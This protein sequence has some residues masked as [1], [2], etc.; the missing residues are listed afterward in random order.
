MKNLIF[1]QYVLLIIVILA[2]IRGL[3]VYQLELNSGVIYKTTSIL[4]LLSGLLSLIKLVTKKNNLELPN[5]KKL[6]LLNASINI[7]YFLIFLIFNNVLPIYLLYTF[8]VFPIIFFLFQIENNKLENSIF[9][10]SIITAFGVFYFFQL[11]INVGYENYLEIINKLRPE[12][13]AI[14]RIGENILSI[15]YQGSNHDAANI[16]V[17]GSLYF[18]SQIYNKKLYKKYFNLLMFLILTIVVLFTGS[19]TN[20]SILLIVLCLSFLKFAK[21]STILKVSFI[22]ILLILTLLFYY[23]EVDYNQYIFFYDKISNPDI[24]NDGGIFN[25]LNLKSFYQSIISILFGFGFTLNVPLINVEIGFIKL[26]IDTGLIPFSILM[27]ILFYPIY[28][29]HLFKSKF[30]NEFKFAKH[31]SV[32]NHF[33]KKLKISALPII[34]GG[35]TLVH[36]SSL[37]RITSIGFYCILFTLFLKQYIELNNIAILFLEMYKKDE[38]TLYS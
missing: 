7:I 24:S 1:K 2:S 28:L 13:D 4:L 27:Y 22:T 23:N 19:V 30:H 6:I 17:M 20:I 8:L 34:A 37:F 5:L 16:L 14:S 21:L 3:L 32:F 35:L 29:I 33:I 18:Y 31:Q 26:L 11:S 38:N 12:E 10:I 15:G 36:Y 25:S 9:L